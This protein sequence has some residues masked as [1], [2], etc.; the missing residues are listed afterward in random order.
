M[1][2]ELLLGRNIILNQDITDLDAVVALELNNLT[3]FLVDDDGAVA[4]KVL[5]EHLDELL[6]LL[7]GEIVLKALNSSQ[8]LATVALLQTNIC[9]AVKEK[10]ERTSS[11]INKRKSKSRRDGQSV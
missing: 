7:R 9:C 5:L 6:D 8:G 1:N 4:A 3:K 2:L 11:T 10:K